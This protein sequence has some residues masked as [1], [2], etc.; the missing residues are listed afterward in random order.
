[1][2]PCSNT[3]VQDIL[4]P[5]LHAVWV[6]QGHCSC[7]LTTRPP[8][9][10]PEDR[11]RARYERRGWSQAKIGRA[12]RDR[13]SAYRRRIPL[14]AGLLEN[15]LTELARRHGSVIV[16]PEDYRG[17]IATEVVSAKASEELTLKE[18]AERGWTLSEG[19]RVTLRRDEAR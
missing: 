7:G 18:W 15:A 2:E 19:T 1:M 9:H 6:T 16:F 17:L 3:H 5:Q 10:E 8:R 12:L 11:L 13:R 14:H 4:G